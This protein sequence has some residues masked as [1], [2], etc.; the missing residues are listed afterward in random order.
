MS[1]QQEHFH[2]GPREVKALDMMKAGLDAKDWQAVQK[3]G[4]G[5]DK[6]AMDSIQGLTT[7]ASI[8]TP[9][10][11]LQNW[12]P[13]F[14]KIVT[15]ARKI[16]E[17]TGISTIGSWEDE[18]I[19]Q[20]VLEVTGTSTP[21]GDYTNVPL[22]SWNVNFVTRTVVRFEE[23]LKVGQLEEA[24][25][26]RMRVSSAESKREGAA[27]ALEIQRN[28]IGFYG[29]NSGNNATYGFLNDP[30]LPN[31]QTVAATGTGS[32][33]TWSTKTFL[34]ICADIRTAIQGLRTQTQ[35][36]VDP[37][38]VNITLAV[39]TAV[40]DYLSTTSD[41]GISVRE[42]LKEAY[43]RVRVV[44]APEL[45]AANSSANVFYLYAENV[46]DNSTDDGRTFIQVVPAKF[47]VVGVAKTAKGYEEDFS[48]ATA[49]IMLKRPFAV[50][51]WTGV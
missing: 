51:R 31:Y 30:N 17:L 26:S 8:N 13:G 14:V 40:V 22:S 24:R 42:W 5:L 27:L 7:T 44:S 20:G 6:I 28:A 32:T 38:G 43:P 34:E 19:V 23:G 33:T 11:F 35:D 9:V 21:Y 47:M 48:N 15:A 36:I 18:Q 29:Y 2:I 41:F 39:A 10:Q 46:P 12:L 49:G 25:A 3:L 4:I 45:S 37:E 1:A 16:D 50:T